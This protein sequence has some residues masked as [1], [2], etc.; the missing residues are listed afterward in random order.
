MTE[1]VKVTSLEPLTFSRYQ[2][3][4]KICESII[5][6]QSKSF[7]AAFSQLPHPDNWAVYAIYA[8]CR[9]ADD[10]ID[11]AEDVD[12]L[13]CLKQQLHDF[14]DKQIILNTPMWRALAVVFQHY[15]MSADPF[16]DMLYGQKQDSQFEQPETIAD[17]S[18]YSYYVAGSVGLMLLPILSDVPSQLVS[19]GKQIGEAMQVTNILRDVGEDFANHRI[20]LPRTLLK[21]HGVDNRM[22]IQE[23][24]SQELIA[25]WEELAKRAES[26]Y[27]EGL[28]L[29]A[30]L[31]PK[32]R[33]PFVAACVY[34]RAIL[35]AVRNNHYQML[36]QRQVVSANHK[37][38]LIPEIQHLI[39]KYS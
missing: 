17:L 32:A 16:Y 19:R 9:Q 21:K 31:K 18:E 10:L 1:T 38:K 24:P 33:F 22:F 11:E 14:I 34:Y 5:K 35:T 39:N 4:F 7:Y 15:P 36:H 12:G 25:A 30:G 20:Y 26:L 27:E 37:F 6:K 3:D 13:E 29:T 2:Q 23:S 28:E 8:F